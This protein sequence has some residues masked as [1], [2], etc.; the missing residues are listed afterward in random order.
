MRSCEISHYKPHSNQ[1]FDSTSTYTRSSSSRMGP[2][3]HSNGPRRSIDLWQV[4]LTMSKRSEL[5]S[6]PN[7]TRSRFKQKS[8]NLDVATS[9]QRQC[10]DGRRSAYAPSKDRHHHSLINSTSRPLQLGQQCDRIPLTVPPMQSQHLPLNEQS[11]G[12]R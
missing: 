10:V 9:R 8:N 2:R 7:L 12:E 5:V 3:S 1:V 6:G 4:A 11:S